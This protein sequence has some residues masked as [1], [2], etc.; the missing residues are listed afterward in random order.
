MYEAFKADMAIIMK[1]LSMLSFDVL[2]RVKEENGEMVPAEQIED[3]KHKIAAFQNNIN[4][5][6]ARY[7]ELLADAIA[8]RLVVLKNAEKLTEH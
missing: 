7:P 4:M 2:E 3:R 1:T 8:E 6:D 5:L